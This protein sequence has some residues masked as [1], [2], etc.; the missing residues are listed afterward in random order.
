M[1]VYWLAMATAVAVIAIPNLKL[2]CMTA[3]EA[4]AKRMLHTINAAQQ[5]FAESN[6]ATGYACTL[7]KLAAARL[8]PNSLESGKD[9]GY[10][11][12]IF[13]CG[14]GAPNGS[15]RAFAHPGTKNV[16]GYW[17]FCTD[18][19]ARVKA[20]PESPADCFDHGVTQP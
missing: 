19:T 20:S 9:K 4:S 17:V 18:Q 16:S 7:G 13:D 8:I 10:L 6:P 1:A 11:F 3:N 5:K 12:E 2:A 14:S 15:Y